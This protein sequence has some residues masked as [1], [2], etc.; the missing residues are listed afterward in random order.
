[1]YAHGRFASTERGKKR[2][3]AVEVTDS[4]QD[5]AHSITFFSVFNFLISFEGYIFART[6]MHVSV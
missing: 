4:Y 2:G 3:M 5:S 6:V 1:M